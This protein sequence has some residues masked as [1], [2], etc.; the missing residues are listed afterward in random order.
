MASDL[1]NEVAALDQRALALLAAAVLAEQ[2]RRR[3][4]RQSWLAVYRV[5]AA[6]HVGEVACWQ[7]KA[8]GPP[9]FLTP[10]HVGPCS[11]DWGRA[12]LEVHA[13]GGLL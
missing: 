12:Q 9:C 13:M 1:R 11:H 10:F 6:R 7:A 8:Y 2:A 4:A 3:F 5:A